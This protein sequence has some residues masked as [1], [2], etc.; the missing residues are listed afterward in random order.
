[1][2]FPK[3][4]A[5]PEHLMEFFEEGLHSLG[6]ICERSWHDRLEVLAEGDAARLWRE[7]GELFSGEVYFRDT[8][9]PD[10]ANAQTEVF[11]GCPLAFRLVEAPLAPAFGPLQSL[12]LNG[13][14]H[15][16]ALERG[17]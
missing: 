5:R 2:K 13:H 4:P 3:V 6:A 12:P 8:S 16:G 11:P 14:Q 7:D 15:E 1:M 9:S 17:S 10:A